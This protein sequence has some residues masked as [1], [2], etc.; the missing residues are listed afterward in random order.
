MQLPSTLIET[1]LLGAA[2][3]VIVFLNLVFTIYLIPLII[4]LLRG[5]T[6]VPVKPK[7][8][9]EAHETSFTILIPAFK[10]KYDNLLS[11]A[12]SIISQT[13]PKELIDVILIVEGDDKETRDAALKVRDLLVENGIRAEVKVRDS[14]RRC[15]AAALNCVLENVKGEI[16]VVLDADD[17]LEKEYLSKLEEAF[18]NQE[19]GAVTA[20]VYREGQS[21]H[22]K[23]LRLD[24]EIWYNVVLPAVYSIS[25]G[26][27]PLS[28]EGLAVRT[29]LLRKVGGFPESL[30]EDGMLTIDIALHGYK[31]LYMNA[32]LVEKAPQTFKS[33]L[34]Q[35]IRWIQGYYQCVK[36]LARK[37]FHMSLKAIAGLL[38]AYMVSILEISAMVSDTIFAIYWGAW[39]LNIQPIVDSIRALYPGPIFYWAFFL[40][41]L[42]NL[43][44]FLTYLYLL[45]RHRKDNLAIYIYTLPIYWYIIGL[46]ALVAPLMPKV[47]YKTER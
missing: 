35:R 47:W 4:V 20:K 30:A 15:K 17:V 13:Y 29:S 39:L 6:A 43:S 46:A 9:E 22:G 27:V 31:V 11:T 14:H 18:K 36:R 16:I 45:A 12:N 41:V 3:L 5:L 25:G 33:H 8:G 7:K 40:L 10:E 1:P 21:L 24:T 28:G 37:A 19:I 2:I 42:G 34:R 44:V 23:L 26:Y 38:L 32:L